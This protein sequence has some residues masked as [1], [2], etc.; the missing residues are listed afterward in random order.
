MSRLSRLSR[1]ASIGVLGLIPCLVS[2]ADDG[3]G[4]RLLRYPD[5]HGDRIAFVYA[6]DLW[7]AGAEGG[8]AR[9]LTSHEGLEIFPK[10]SPDGTRIA[11]SGEYGGTRQVYV[12]PA[13]GGSPRQLTYYNDVGSMPPRGGFDNRVLGWTPDGDA[14]LFRGNRLPWGVRMGR[15]FTVPVAGGLETPLAIPEGGGGDL[16]PDGT[17]MAYTPIDREFRTWKRYRGGRAQDVWI[18]DLE[19]NT[20]TRV[21]ENPATDNQ[22]CWLGGKVYFTSDRNGKLNLF[23]YDPA[24]QEQRQV[25]HHEDFDVLWPSAGPSS[26]V[27]QCGGWIWKLDPA[28]GEEAHRVPI[29]VAGDFPDTYPRVRNVKDNVDWFEISPT[30]K[31]ALFAARGDVFTVPAK[32][33]EIRDLTRTQGI[34]EMDPIW[35]PDGRWIAYWSDRTDEYE[36]WVRAHDGSGNERRV[37]NG[38]DIWPFAPVWSPDSKKIA[39]GDKKQRLRWVDVETGEIHDADRGRFGDIT[40]YTWSPDSR[41]I[42]YTKDAE[43]Q[44]AVIWLHDL[45]SGTSTAL[46]EPLTDNWNPAFGPDG[47]YLYFLSNRD[48]HLKFSA[49]E[50]NYLYEKPT[51]VFVGTLR[52][53]VARPFEPQSD[54]E[55]PKASEANGEDEKP[56][57]KDRSEA[58]PGGDAAT[59]QDAPAKAEG[60]EAKAGSEGEADAGSGE[61][62]EGAAEAKDEK[63]EELHV[64]IDVEGFENRVVVIPGP[65]ANYSGLRGV[66]KGVLYVRANDAGRKLL[67]YDLEAREEKT[68]LE[69]MGGW[70]LSADRKKILYSAGGHYGIVD[71]APGQKTSSGKLDLSGMEMKIDPRAE[72]AQIFTDGWRITRDWFYDPGM[73]GQDW[74]AVREK[75]GALVPFVAHRGD[76]DFLLGEMGGELCSGHFY[77]NRGDEPR[78]ERKDNG[79]LGCELEADPS[80]FYVVRKIFRGENW[81]PD[82]RSPLTEPGVDVNEGDFLIAID[83]ETVT[84]DFNPYLFLEGKAERPVTLLVNDK[85]QREGA[86]EEHVRPI[87]RETNLRYLDWVD[88][89]RRIV[90]ERSQGRIGYIHVPNTSTAGNRELFK[91]FY[92]QFTKDALI[93]DV[94]YNGGGFIPDRMIE[95]LDRPRLSYWVWR[96]AAKPVPTPGLS[97]QGPKACLINHYSSSGGDAFPYY[98]R[99]RGLGK[100]IGTRTWGGLI[101]I[102]GNPGFVDGGSLNVPRFRFLDTQGHWAIENEGVSPDIE[103]WDTPDRV[104]RGEDPTLERAIEELREEL[105]KN[106]PHEVEIP[107]APVY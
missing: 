37:T 73:H 97:H 44:V 70:E 52:K 16:A 81:H 107:P 32:H 26:I 34:R 6:G 83:G 72:W 71:A 98:F 99:E 14:V 104:A 102:S 11:F 10:F 22:P 88:S 38:Q 4:T 7:I 50:F 24:T 25:T 61:P 89:R 51:R 93:I 42:A 5:I 65:S 94:R 86:R 36:L 30:G 101:G 39:Y 100:L 45:E 74:P 53:D 92:A 78:P 46:T 33:G 20:A 95:L 103:V 49:W 23:A 9:R 66:D 64:G 35:S 62:N 87:R 54:E 1:M 75:Y 40:S 3:G 27:Y 96:G 82:F 85:P 17:R 31:R 8:T 48:F 28:S 77:V 2:R 12:I 90:E 84:T 105:R 47:K 63:K 57:K 91:N 13:E 56:A 58:E 55:E 18:Y 106:P 29:R 80:G 76:L 59:P 15:Y 43:N 69:G 60:Q 21:T 79:L 67:L 19:A 41:W 68:I